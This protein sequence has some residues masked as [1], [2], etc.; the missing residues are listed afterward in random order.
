MG[1][2]T[3][4]ETPVETLHQITWGAWKGLDTYL[5]LVRLRLFA[6]FGG[7]HS[8]VVVGTATQ[9]MLDRRFNYRVQPS[10]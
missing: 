9:E 3:A 2:Y 1:G 8:Q 10:K 7:P 6:Q 4:D 5:I